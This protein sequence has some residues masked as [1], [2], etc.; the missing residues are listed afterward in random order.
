M[1]GTT[2]APLAVVIP[3]RLALGDAEPDRGWVVPR[4]P[5]GPSRVIADAVA[6]VLV[7]YLAGA[8]VL[9]MVG[10]LGRMTGT[11]VDWR[12]LRR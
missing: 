4:R 11:S 3:N 7:G 1:A 5:A 8:A 10:Q 12:H 6:T 2:I 9:M